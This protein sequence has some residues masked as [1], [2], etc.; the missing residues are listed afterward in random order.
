MNR[1]AWIDE[2]RLSG[3]LLTL[4]AV[5]FLLAAGMPLWDSSGTSVYMMPLPDRLSFILGN[6]A[7]WGWAWA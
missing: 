2:R 7:L 6:P 3:S 4:G 5:T 1:S